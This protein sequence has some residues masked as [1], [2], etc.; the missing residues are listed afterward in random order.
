MVPLL[1]LALFADATFG[2][3]LSIV[4]KTESEFRIDGTAPADTRYVLQASRDLQDWEDVKDEVWGQVE[5]TFT[6]AG[7]TP[8]FFRLAPWVPLAPITV[9][10]VGDSTVA[11]LASNGN[12]FSGWGQG[13]Y[14]Y[15]KPEARVVNFAVPGYGTR[16]FLSSAEKTK[17]I[18]LKPDFVLVQFG[19]IDAFYCGGEPEQCFTTYQ[20]YTDNLKT[21]V[22]TIRDFHGT[23]IL[24]TQPVIKRFDDQGKVVAWVKDRCDIVRALAPE[25]QTDLVDLS[26]LSMDLFNQ[27]GED[28]CAYIISPVPGNEAHYTLEGARVMAGLVVSALPKS[29]RPYVVRDGGAAVNP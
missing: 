1:C 29:L 11:D 16:K 4:K 3:S 5:Y 12:W 6:S 7:V 2:Q 27:L 9:V 24:V 15:F 22:Q 13:I 8:R 17:M 10:L 18:A 20:E 19:V 25:L 21:I 28:G 14:G 26:Q 23:P